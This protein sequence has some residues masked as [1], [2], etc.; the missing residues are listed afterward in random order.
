[1]GKPRIYGLLYMSRNDSI[2]EEF[3]FTTW[4]CP[5]D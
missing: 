4:V 3:S 1:M 2:V 5:A